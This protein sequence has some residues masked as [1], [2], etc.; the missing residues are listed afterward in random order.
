VY[1]I[2]MAWPE[3]GEVL[4]KSLSAV[5]PYYE[6]EIKNVELL[7]FGEVPF[8]SENDG[9]KVVL[10]EKKSSNMALVLKIRNDH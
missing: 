3:N 10:P 5:S 7:G 8:A 9:L 6:K 1:A 4:I 2:V